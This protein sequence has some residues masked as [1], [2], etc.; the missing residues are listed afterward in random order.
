MQPG[1][2]LLLQAGMA[3]DGGGEHA[4]GLS[5]GILPEQHGAQHVARIAVEPAPG[6][7]VGP[8]HF[9]GDGPAAGRGPGQAVAQQ[10]R[11]QQALVGEGAALPGVE[12]EAFPFLGRGGQRA[13]EGGGGL[14]HG[15]QTAEAAGVAGLEEKVRAQACG[16]RGQGAAQ[17]EAAGGGTGVEPGE[18]FVIAAAGVEGQGRGAR[19]EIGAELVVPEG[20]LFLGRGQVEAGKAHPP[21][22]FQGAGAGQGLH[23]RGLAP[24]G[25]GIDLQPAGGG[26][27]Q[28]GQAVIAAAVAP[29]AFRARDLGGQVVGIAQHGL[30]FQPLDI[31]GIGAQQAAGGPVGAF[32]PG[33]EHRL[34]AVRAHDLLRTGAEQQ[35]QHDRQK[36][37]KGKGR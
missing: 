4:P 20:A 28:Q 3:D 8:A 5:R 17:L 31:A 14:H 25:V 9:A 22:G 32:R 21:E 24:Q 16:G 29:Q 34:A 2:G 19:A 6:L 33:Q 36:P 30:A 7:A 13:P 12:G 23:G 1:Q 26:I 10:G 35:G 11:G 15:V 27:Q 18:L 37:P